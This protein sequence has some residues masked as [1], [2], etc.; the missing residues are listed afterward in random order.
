[1]PWSV[2]FQESCWSARVRRRSRPRR[3]RGCGHAVV[4]VQVSAVASLGGVHGDVSPAQQVAGIVADVSVRYADA[5]PNSQLMAGDDHRFS[6]RRH[7]APGRAVRASRV[8]KS[9]RSIKATLSLW[10]A[11]QF[12]ALCSRSLNNT[13]L[14]SAV[15]ASWVAP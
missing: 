7:D 9:S 4:V 6:Q 15:R 5:G 10:P 2:S 11:G 12:S 14:G 1:M 8:L 3:L 13:R